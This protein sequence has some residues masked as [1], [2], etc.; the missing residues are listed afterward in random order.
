MV[1]T[2]HYLCRLHNL[3]VSLGW[4]PWRILPSAE[5]PQNRAKPRRGIT[6]EEHALI[7]NAE[8]NEERR[9]FYQLLWESRSQVK[10]TSRLPVTL[11]AL[12]S[13]LKSKCWTT[14]S[15]DTPATA[16]FAKW[17]IGPGTE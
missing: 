17:V 12:G 14:S 5:W 6:P 3:A 13:S 4:L 1:S 10:R 2:N 11:F 9:S 16:R 15:S 7:I 8:G